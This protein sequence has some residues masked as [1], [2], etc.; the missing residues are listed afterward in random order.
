MCRTHLVILFMESGVTMKLIF[1]I[2]VIFFLI[3]L[4]SCKSSND[5]ELK[6]TS[7]IF[8]SNTG[9]SMIGIEDKIGILGPDFIAGQGNKFM[10]HFWGTKDEMNKK[11]FRV[12]A[13]NLKTM[14]K[15]MALILD[16]G[17]S[18]E[19]HV[20][21]YNFAPAG[22]NN[23]ADAHLPSNLSL[24]SK[25]LWQLNAYIGGNLQGS[26]IVEVK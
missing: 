26:L 13:I 12:E 11:P 9:A 24:A 8:K 4:V 20:W 19:R 10:W 17:T 15:N 6:T 22:P 14:K 7:P 18:N 21:E 1:N 16:A 5:S 2:S 3:F 23:G 25:G